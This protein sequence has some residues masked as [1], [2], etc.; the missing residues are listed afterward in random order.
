MPFLNTSHGRNAC[1]CAERARVLC[2]K[3]TDDSVSQLCASCP[4]LR[5]VNL[6]GCKRLTDVTAKALAALR[7][8]A[9]LD[10]T[11]C[12][13]SDG[14]LTAVALSAGACDNLAH[15]NLYAVSTYTDKSF[16]CVGVL[17]RLTFLDV[18]GSQSLTDRA[19]L[20]IAEG[21]GLLS[22]LNLSWCTKL[23]D[24]GLCAVGEGCPL[25]ELLSVHGNRN[26][27]NR[28]VSTLAAHNRGPRL[29]T[30]DVN[31]CVG[32]TE[33]QD[34]LRALIPSLTTFVYHS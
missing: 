23:T 14:G 21:C 7:R 31:G 4:E 22:Y 28:F 8:L 33:N 2:P 27:T 12:A 20:E 25:L 9:F 6:S 19:L 13:F 26:V 24:V 3:V 5:K 1:D 30:L 11:R 16:A 17:S 34:E 29:K 32:V 15:L 10:I 18:C